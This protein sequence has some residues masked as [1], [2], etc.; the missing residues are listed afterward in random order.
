LPVKKDFCARY[1]YIA[2]VN[3]NPQLYPVIGTFSALELFH[4]SSPLRR[5]R[6]RF[7]LMDI[8]YLT[9]QTAEDVDAQV[10][11]QMKIMAML[12]DLDKFDNWVTP[13]IVL[14]FYQ[15]ITLLYLSLFIV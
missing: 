10:N 7:L 2:L 6:G 9:S 1:I 11:M 13:Y 5:L 4:L 12:Y 8:I 3:N 15:P 14:C